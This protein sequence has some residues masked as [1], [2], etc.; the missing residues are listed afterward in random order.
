MKKSLYLFPLLCL[1][2][3]PLAHGEIVIFS[4]ITNSDFCKRAED[5]AP[6]DRF[7]EQAAQFLLQ[8]QQAG[9]LPAPSSPLNTNRFFSH[10]LDAKKGG[11]SN[12]LRQHSGKIQR[13]NTADFDTVGYYT[14]VLIR[15]YPTEVRQRQ[16]WGI[17][18]DTLASAPDL[19]QRIRDNWQQLNSPQQPK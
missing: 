16:M 2:G 3:A 1:I 6:I 13:M 11:C 10:W 8:Q 5:E 14:Y 4:G 12:S 18:E 15:L 17:L 9:T 7:T 19:L